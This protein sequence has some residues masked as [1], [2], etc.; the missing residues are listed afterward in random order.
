M[1]S[2]LRG[3]IKAPVRGYHWRERLI[4]AAFLSVALAAQTPLDLISRR[5][6]EQ[7][8]CLADLRNYSYTI[9]FPRHEEESRYSGKSEYLYSIVAPNGRSLFASR[10]ELDRRGNVSDTLIRRELRTSGAGPE[11]ILPVPFTALFQFA[12]S[13]NERFMVIAGRLQ[14]PT[15]AKDKRDGIFVLNRSTGSVH[16]L[17]PYASRTQ[18]I[19]SFNVS[20]AGDLVIYE[21]KEAVMIFTGSDGHLTLTDHHA[22][23]LPVLMPDGR[24]Y[25]YSDRGQLILNDGKAKRKLLSSPNVVGAIRVSPGAQFLAFGIDLFGDLSSTEL[26]ICELKAL[27]CVDGPKYS[28]WIAGRETFWVRR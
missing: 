8:L 13:L 26:R 25:V 11:E 10:R 9:V 7:R 22:G 23:K 5:I 12:V 6:T 20:D 28:D 27:A 17:A 3:V 15:I 2:T 1:G 14:G 16:P 19:R 21:D 4:V 24:G 18:D